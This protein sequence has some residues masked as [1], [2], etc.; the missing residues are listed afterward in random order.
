MRRWLLGIEVWSF[1][2]RI[3][4]FGELPHQQASSLHQPE[5]LFSACVFKRSYY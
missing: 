1:P 2:L 3:I 5:K 4:R